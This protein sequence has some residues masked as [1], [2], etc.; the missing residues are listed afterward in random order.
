VALV[1]AQPGVFGFQLE[2]GCAVIK[3]FTNALNS[4]VASAAS[5]PIS[6]NVTGKKYFINLLVART[7]N[8]WIKCGNIRCMAV[9][10]NKWLT[11]A[12]PL[13]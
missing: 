10:A 1:T 6:I 3:F 7:A 9:F 12:A 8:G 2:R 13:V 5:V 4:I 11:V